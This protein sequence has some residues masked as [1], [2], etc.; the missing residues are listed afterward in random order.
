MLPSE[1]P[2]SQSNVP[3]DSTCENSSRQSSSDYDNSSSVYTAMADISQRHIFDGHGTLLCD[4]SPSGKQLLAGLGILHRRQ[5][6][7]C[8]VLRNTST[9]I[10]SSNMDHYF[11][12]LSPVVW[13]APHLYR[14]L[15]NQWT[16]NFLRRPRPP[17]SAQRRPALVSTDLSIT[18][19]SR[20]IA[21][22]GTSCSVFEVD[23]VAIWIGWSLGL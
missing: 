16:W 15:P 19:A 9:G 12:V 21:I 18:L 23:L 7:A 11:N 17:R 3:E 20:V 14:H 1:C 4:Q 13:G 10:H 2:V 5:F 6:A 22:A 8:H